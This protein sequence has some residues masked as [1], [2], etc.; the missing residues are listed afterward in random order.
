VAVRPRA[1]HEERMVDLNSLVIFAKVVEANSFSEGARRLK[2]PLSTVS[3]RIGELEA[4][5]GV[6]LLERSTRKF[7][8]TSIGEQLLAHAQ[9]S[10]ELSDAVA[11]VVSYQTDTVTGTLRLSAPPS[12]SDSVLA[13]VIG[14]FQAQYPEVQVLVLVTERP[15]DHIHEGVD[16]AFR[17]GPIKDSALVAHRL[18]TYRHRLLATPAYLERTRPPESPDDL[19]E[20]RILS[21]AHNLK[22]QRTW[23]F[24]QA[25]G[26]KQV[27]L[28]IQPYLS[29]NDYAGLSAALLANVGIGDLPPIVQPRLVREGL[30]VEVMP[31]WRFGTFNLSLL[32]VNRQLPNHVGLFKRLAVEMVPRLFPDLPT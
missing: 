15:I 18:L 16:L 32:Q 27:A 31:K 26:P 4:E 13:P 3:R 22:P 21:F 25:D 14:A 8:L 29:M 5:L 2:L 1:T 20:H 24:F 11:S 10:A 9:Q 23:N 30:L 12:I 19:L 6:R 7:R 28:E 17:V